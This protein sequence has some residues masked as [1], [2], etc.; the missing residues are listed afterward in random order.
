MSKKTY[1]VTG[2]TPYND[3]QPGEQFEAELDE[4]AEERAIERGAIKVVKPV[5]KGKD[6]G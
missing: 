6:D 5:A 2:N 3:H 4:D 1:E